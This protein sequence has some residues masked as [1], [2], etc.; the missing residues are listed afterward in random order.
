MANKIYLHAESVTPDMANW[1]NIDDQGRLYIEYIDLK[2]CEED[3]TITITTPED[4]QINIPVSMTFR[5]K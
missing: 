4:G 5:D 2:R 3:D 1:Y